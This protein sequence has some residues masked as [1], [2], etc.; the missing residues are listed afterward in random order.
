MSERARPRTAAEH[1]RT[2]P[3]FGSEVRL[4]IG[5]PDGAG[6]PPPP[7][8]ALQ[9]QGFLRALHRRLTRFD[10][11]SELCSLNADPA[12]VRAV[13]SILLAAVAAARWAAW[14]SGGLVDPTL[15]AELER[16]GYT[17]SWTEER[18][19]SIADALAAAPKR[20]PAA[21]RPGSGWT[22]I[23][24]DPVRGVVRRAP[25]VRIDTGG[26][27]KGLAADLAF[28]W[29]SGYASAVVDAGGDLRIGGTRPEPRLVRIEHPLDDRFA[30]EF[31]LA[32]GAVATSGIKTRLWRTETG[33]G[34]HLLDPS[35]GEPAWTG[36]IQATAVGATA[37]EAETLAKTAF[38]SG[39][40]RAREVL[41]ERGG[42]VV[43]DDGSVEILGSL[44]RPAVE[45]IAA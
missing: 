3:L 2:F 26:T 14:R 5:E 37:L 45:R 17:E 7:V 12:D 22:S 43:L 20:R 6:L 44:T 19:A 41:S 40:E 21:R 36:L 13:G 18:S 28:E 31:A 8:I 33:F 29:L 9:L 15:V 38:L 11:G 32:E 1:E 39:P 16:A 25:G 4:L 23:D 27:G 24:V 30:H 35:T 42:L 34:H 10:P